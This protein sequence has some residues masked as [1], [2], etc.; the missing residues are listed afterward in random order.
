MPCR[1][2]AKDLPNRMS[3]R[4]MSAHPDTSHTFSLVN[5]PGGFRPTDSIRLMAMSSCSCV[6]KMDGF[7]VVGKSGMMMKPSN[8]IG[9]VMTPSTMKSPEKASV[10]R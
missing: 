4:K 8:A 3:S 10:S 7:V 2:K 6:Y 5:F 9:M 1:K